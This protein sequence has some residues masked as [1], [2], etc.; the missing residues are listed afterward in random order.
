MYFWLVGLGLGNRL[1]VLS[2][3]RSEIQAMSIGSIVLLSWYN[4]SDWYPSELVLERIS[5][6]FMLNFYL[7]FII[8]LIKWREVHYSVNQINVY[9]EVPRCFV[10]NLTYVLLLILF[11]ATFYLS[12]STFRPEFS[13]FLSLNY[14]VRDLET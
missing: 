8:P 1:V 6:I 7:P 13:K 10:L 12:T 9:L 3:V 14:D 2:Y 5:N 4:T 11:F